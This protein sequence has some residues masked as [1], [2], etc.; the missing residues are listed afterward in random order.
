MPPSDGVSDPNASERRSAD[1]PPLAPEAR[2]RLSPALWLATALVVIAS[3]LMLVVGPIAAGQATLNG[4]IGAGYFALGAVGL[5]LVYGV[6]R[7]INF[8][9]GDLLTVGMYLTLAAIALG[10]PFWLAAAF[11]ML[12]TSLVTVLL[13]R[14]I[15]EPMRR[16]RTSTLQ[17]FLVATGLALVLRYSVQFFAGSQVRAV[18]LDTTSSVDLGHWHLSEPYSPRQGDA[19]CRRQHVLGR[20]ERHRHPPH[21]RCDLAHRGRACGARRHPLCGVDWLD[22]SQ[23]RLHHLAQP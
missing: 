5:T 22:Q 6:I 10:A 23:F 17:L 16:A 18:G 4:L 3:A 2:Y 20:G 9:H 7:L 13:D 21:H 19:C 14:I 15:W 8:A 11:A 1:A 12:A